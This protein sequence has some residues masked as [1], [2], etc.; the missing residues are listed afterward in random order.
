MIRRRKEAVGNMVDKNETVFH[1]ISDCKKIAQKYMNKNDLWGLRYI[2]NSVRYTFH[3][4]KGCYMDKIASVLENERHKIYC[5][6]KI[7][8]NNINQAADR[9]WS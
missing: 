4:T 7:Q 6:F 9:D 8:T 3:F 1:L 5:D 2:E